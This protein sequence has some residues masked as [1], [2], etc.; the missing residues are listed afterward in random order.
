MPSTDTSP[1]DQY[2][3]A[4]SAEE[5]GPELV[6][7]VDGYY[8]FLRRTGVIELQK[9]CF[10]YYYQ[11]RQ[12]G[13]KVYTTGEQEEFLNCDVADYRNIV[14]HLVGMTTNQRPSFEPRAANTD[15]KSQAQ[16]ILAQGLLDYYL[17]ELKIDED[18]DKA[19]ELGVAYG[20]GWLRLD[21]NPMAGEEFALEEEEPG[22]DLQEGMKAKSREA[23]EDAEEGPKPPEIVRDGDLEVTRYGMIDVIRDW[24]AKSVKGLHWK[25]TRDFKDKHLVA[26][27]YP[28]MRERILEASMSQKDKDHT[29]QSHLIQDT[30][31]IPLYTFFHEKNAAIPDGRMTV[32]VG[33][34]AIL[35]DGPLP[36]KRIP[37]YPLMPDTQDDT[38]F[39]WTI[40]FDLLPLQEAENNLYGTIATNV[41]NFGISN[42]AVPRGSNMTVEELSEGLNLLEYDPKYGAPT[43]LDLV[44][45]SNDVYKFLEMVERKME[46]ISG[47]NSVNRGNPEA[48]LKSG[49]ALAL[50][51][52]MALQFNMQLQ[53]SYAR[54]MESVGTGIIEI[55]QSFAATERVTQIAG[56]SQRSYMKKW[57]GAD[58]DKITRVI[59]DLGNP[60]ARTTAGKIEMADA[61]MERGM[62]ESPDQYIQVMTTGRLEPMIEG[63]QAELMNIRSENEELGEGKQQVAVFTDNH[64][65]HI[66]EHKNVLASPDSRR[67]PKLVKVVTEHIQEHLN[68]LRG[69][70][71]VML[72]LMGQNPP[73]PQAPAPG[74]GSKPPAPSGVPEQMASLLNP[75]SSGPDLPNMPNMPNPPTNP[76]TGERANLEPGG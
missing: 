54:L 8:D 3:A 7:R 30:D 32:F 68:L 6:K 11:S 70:D 50:V 19:V 13:G 14:K 28:A 65:L 76:L 63:K 57:K 45:V 75:A 25:I 10:K 18:T 64:G 1:K 31:L 58:L 5:L 62:I 12:S 71:P 61:L 29:L 37:L 56:R 47:V 23:E 52:S 39:G 15:H 67:N 48:S 9:R 72:S 21:W 74:N 16:V 27:E 60:L 44:N 22:E 20:E 69:T 38:P 41:S 4:K 73:P 49:A 33:G 51:Q 53:K 17:R 40:G 42:I 46:T 35:Y 34:D 26:A 36:F 43:V 2:W 24:T 59:V 55:L 66:M